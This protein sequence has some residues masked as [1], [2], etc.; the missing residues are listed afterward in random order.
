M[1]YKYTRKTMDPTIKLTVPTVYGD[2]PSFLGVP[3]ARSKEDLKGMDAVFL[4][5]GGSGFPKDVV[6][7]WRHDIGM[8]F[9]PSSWLGVEAD[10]IT[11]AQRLR[12]TSL[13]YGDYIPEFEIEVFKHVKLVDYGDQGRDLK[14]LGE[15]LDAGCIPIAMRC[16]RTG[17]LVKAVA[18]HT[19]GKVGVI[20]LDSHG[21][22]AMMPPWLGW[23]DEIANIEKVDMTKFVHIGFHG[24]RNFKEQHEWL[25][26]KGAHVFMPWKE[27]KKN[28]MEAVAKEAVEIVHDGTDSQVLLFNLDVLDMSVAPG[29]DEFLG[30]SMS[31]VLTLFHEVGKSG[32]TAF[33]VIWAPSS[34]MPMY[35]A[36]T[37][38]I[39]WL[40][41]GLGIRKSARI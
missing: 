4:G 17:E 41:A 2:T 7:P 28:G 10:P 38:S 14:K 36:I 12:F 18:D 39:L 23:A 8:R 9:N 11:S 29:L 37:W 25:K 15:V 30:I 31:D 5:G 6:N 1:E 40:L 35:H 3:V 19:K 32:F 34:I 20:A 22:C 16:C 13:K 24:P 21:D 27:I 33:N 26:D